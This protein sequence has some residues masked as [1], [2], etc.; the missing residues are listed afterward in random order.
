MKPE[1][2]PR[3]LSKKSW[4]VRFYNDH[5]KAFAEPYLADLLKG[6][7][8]LTGLLIFQVVIVTLRVLGYDAE[9]LRLLEEAHF[10]PQL[11]VFWYFGLSFVF[12][13]IISPFR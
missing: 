4:I 7:M 6:V 9:R 11:A 12:R 10:W 8:V 3:R 13:L 2:E 5:I 1:G